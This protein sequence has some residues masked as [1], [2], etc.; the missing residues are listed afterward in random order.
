MWAVA[1]TL[2]SLALA[3]VGPIRVDLCTLTERPGEFDGKV[4][5]VRARFTDL[6][7]REWA[8]DDSCFRPVLIVLRSDPKS[9][10]ELEPSAGTAVS[11]LSKSLNEPVVVFA[12]FIGRFEWTGSRNIAGQAEFF[13]RSRST[14]RLVLRDVKDL[15]RVVVPRR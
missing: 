3:Q 10:P 6:K 12:R 1:A 5:D 9:L 2:S 7:N 4:I 8:M 14:M 11:V 13:G 15:E